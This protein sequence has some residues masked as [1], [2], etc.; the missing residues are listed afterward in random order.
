MATGDIGGQVL[1]WDMSKSTKS[2][3]ILIARFAVD[4]LKGNVKISPQHHQVT[5]LAFSRC[6]NVLTAGTIKGEIVSWDI[7]KTIHDNDHDEGLVRK[8]SKNHKWKQNHLK[9]ITTTILF[10]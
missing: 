1:F 8:M 10:R 5:A 2:D 7:Q 9:H 4:E 6:G 3:E